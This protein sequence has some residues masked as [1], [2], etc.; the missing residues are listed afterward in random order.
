LTWTRRCFDFMVSAPREVSAK[1]LE[2][3][4]AVPHPRRVL[5]ELRQQGCIEAAFRQGKETF[6]RVRPG[7]APPVDRREIH[8]K[9]IQPLGV[10]AKQLKRRGR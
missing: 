4:Y 5:G 6:W 3:R 1:D 10:R 7:A 2:V 8:A 9:R